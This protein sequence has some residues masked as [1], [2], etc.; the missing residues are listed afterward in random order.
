MPTNKDAPIAWRVERKK[1]MKKV[2]RIL[3]VALLLGSAG[4][5]VMT[6]TGCEDS[7]VDVDA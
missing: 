5:G 3:L 2:L 7:G 6:L 1:T 4:V